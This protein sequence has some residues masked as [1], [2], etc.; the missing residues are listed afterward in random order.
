M[1]CIIFVYLSCWKK[2]THLHYVA[3]DRCPRPN[4]FRKTVPLLTVDAFAGPLC[5]VGQDD[6]T[7]GYSSVSIKIQHYS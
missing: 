7:C 4:E 2:R 1:C 3:K 5:P 6:Q